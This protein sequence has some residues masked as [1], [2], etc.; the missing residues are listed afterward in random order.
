MINSTS[1]LLTGYRQIID[2]LPTV[3]QQFMS[4]NSV[5]QQA[6]IC[7]LSVGQH[8]AVCWPRVGQQVI[9]GAV[10]HL[11]RSSSEAVAIVLGARGIVPVVCS[12]LLFSRIHSCKT[13][14]AATQPLASRHRVCLM[15]EQAN[16][17]HFSLP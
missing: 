8:S 15:F 4:A 17:K 1:S 14:R 9:L 11:Y 2:I 7:E 13:F 16:T 6:A 5:S 3:S 10:L 12:I